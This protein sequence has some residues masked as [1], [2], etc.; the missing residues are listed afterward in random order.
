MPKQRHPDGPKVNAGISLREKTELAE[1]K[2]FAK[3]AKFPSVSAVVSF[4]IEK[5]LP[6]EKKDFENEILDHEIRINQRNS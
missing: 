6:I 1:L 5:Y 2:D 4:L 3:A